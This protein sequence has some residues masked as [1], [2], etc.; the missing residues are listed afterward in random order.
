[1]NIK[2]LA[3]TCIVSLFALCASV[4]TS[5][6]QLWSGGYVQQNG[7]PFSYF[8]NVTISNVVTS[9]GTNSATNTLYTAVNQTITTNLPYITNEALV[10]GPGGTLLNSTNTPIFT[11]W[12][13]PSITNGAGRILVVVTGTATNQANVLAAADLI[14]SNAYG[15][16]SNSWTSPTNANLTP[17]T[18]T[19]SMFA[20][21]NSVISLKTNRSTT[22]F[23]AGPLT[24][25]FNCTVIG[26]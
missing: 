10:S 25:G 22:T 9:N 7:I 17:L 12:N 1:M 13:S 23:P 26:L 2:N 16:F 14:V 8:T 21:S 19:L 18:F 11:N 24:G 3:A 6:A 20:D 5:Q 4:T 15:V